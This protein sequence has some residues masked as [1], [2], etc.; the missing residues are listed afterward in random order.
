MTTTTTTV[1]NPVAF[2]RMAALLCAL[3]LAALVAVVA[4]AIHRFAPLWQPVGIVVAAFV[5]ALEASVVHHT[6]QEEHLGMGDMMRYLV[7]EL[8][9][10]ALMMR[11]VTSLSLPHGSIEQTLNNWLYD[12][13]SFFDA[14]FVVHIVIGVL[15]GFLAHR[16]MRDL[17]EL[18]PSAFDS[19]DTR[20]EGHQRVAVIAAAERTQALARIGGRFG[21]GAGLLLLALSLE[22]V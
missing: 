2:N 10:L 16:T 14:L 21:I 17:R 3:M 7:P 9:V 4:G 15:I 8:V 18:S 6:G 1:T 11:L 12:P 22:A 13:L 19:A 5:I 20:L